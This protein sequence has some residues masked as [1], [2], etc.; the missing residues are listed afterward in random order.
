[1]ARSAWVTRVTVGALALA[2][3]ALGPST[4]AQATTY[5][6]GTFVMKL[7]S[8]DHVHLY[9]GNVAWSGKAVT[10][11]LQGWRLEIVAYEAYECLLDCAWYDWRWYLS[12]GS[13]AIWG[14]C[15]HSDQG[16]CLSGGRDL[17]T[18]SVDTT[19]AIS[20]GTGQYAGASGSAHLKGILGPPPGEVK[21]SGV[22]EARFEL[23]L[24]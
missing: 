14:G 8:V 16:F 24:N 23:L 19:A 9:Y 15:Y 17:Y 1:M 6:A 13:D 4:H 7:G 3:V 10:G 21:P 18:G 20:G 2:L 12:N 11:D 5:R 22:G